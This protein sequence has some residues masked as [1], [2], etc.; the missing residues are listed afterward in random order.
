MSQLDIK[1]VEQDRV[2]DHGRNGRNGRMDMGGRLPLP[3]PVVI[4]AP[5]HEGKMQTYSAGD[6]LH[7]CRMADQK[8]NAGDWWS[9]W[10]GPRAR[11]GGPV[12]GKYNACHS[13]KETQ[14]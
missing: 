1:T 13:H 6:S 8:E 3:L 10:I 4:A 2:V 11:G 9:S 12:G 14:I 5:T 7:F